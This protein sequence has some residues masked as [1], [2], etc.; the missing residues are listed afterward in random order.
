M[1]VKETTRAVHLADK[2]LAS[3]DEEPTG[4]SFPFENQ[5]LTVLAM[6][7]IQWLGKAGKEKP[8]LPITG[9][10]PHSHTLSDGRP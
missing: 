6:R 2:T 9:Q 10:V 1:V 8:R 5:H 7:K 3:P 4:R